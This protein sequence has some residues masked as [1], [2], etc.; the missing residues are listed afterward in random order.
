MTTPALPMFPICKIGLNRT[1]NI[2]SAIVSK[3][4]DHALIGI[5]LIRHHQIDL[6]HISEIAYLYI[7]SQPA[8]VT[9]CI[10]GTT[11]AVLTSVCLYTL[12]TLHIFANK[13]NTYDVVYHAQ[14]DTVITRLKSLGL[15]ETIQNA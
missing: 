9:Y 14:L 3:P 5:Q 15:W 12:G 10:K 2:I 6:P 8:Y 11:P 4:T 7:R 13:I 1:N